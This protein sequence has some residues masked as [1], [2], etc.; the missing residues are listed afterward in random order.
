[1]IALHVLAVVARWLV[2]GAYG[3]P[4]VAALAA[5]AALAG[6]AVAAMSTSWHDRIVRLKHYAV[7]HD[8]RA[9]V[10]CGSRR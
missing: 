9:L 8:R 3:G 7:H 4:R 10:T 2:Y 1:M 5:Y 6:V